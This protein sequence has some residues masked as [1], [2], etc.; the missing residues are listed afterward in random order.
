[1]S[2]Q[3]VNSLTSMHVFVSQT[4]TL[5]IPHSREARLQLP[6]SF[7]VDV[8]AT[9]K[10]LVSYCTLMREVWTLTNVIAKEKSAKKTRQMLARNALMMN[11]MTGWSLCLCLLGGSCETAVVGKIESSWR[12]ERRSEDRGWNCCK[13][14]TE[15][16]T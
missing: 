5:A 4:L 3:H 2:F 8:C 10:R 14:R 1:M 7:L 15:A 16:R 12:Y 9:K 13:G 11:F 6:A